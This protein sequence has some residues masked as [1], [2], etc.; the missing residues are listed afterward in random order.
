MSRGNHI[1]L[2]E[3]LMGEDREDKFSHRCFPQ[4]QDKGSRVWRYLDLA[5]F[6]WLL[7][8]RKLFLSRLDLVNDPHE[9]SATQ[10]DVLIYKRFV[11]AQA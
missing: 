9:G 10:R 2:Q 3:A 4:P 8:K 5:E 7:D 6:I 1:G 11:T